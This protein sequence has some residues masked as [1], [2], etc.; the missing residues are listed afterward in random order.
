MFRALVRKNPLLSSSIRTMT[1]E[2]E[3]V[4][5]PRRSLLY[6]PGSS[7]KMVAKSVTLGADTIVLDMEDGV[8][9]NAKVCVLSSFS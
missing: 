7:E 8:A 1:T 2:A 3:S 4:F 9:A 6:I 5:R